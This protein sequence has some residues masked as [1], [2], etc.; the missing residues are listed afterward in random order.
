MVMNIRS[1]LLLIICTALLAG[2]ACANEPSQKAQTRCGWFDNPTPGNASLFDP[3]GEWIIGIQGGHQA[4]G[5]WPDFTASQWVN[6]NRSYGY[7]CAC[8]DVIADPR[9]HEVARI[10]SARARALGVCRRNPALKGLR[11]EGRVAVHRPQ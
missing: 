8:L 1:T 9:T 7:G 3:D 4:G 6:T 2:A 11:P 5:D 10:H